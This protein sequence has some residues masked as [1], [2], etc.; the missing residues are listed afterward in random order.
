MHLS[1]SLTGNLEPSSDQSV[2]RTMVFPLISDVILLE[3]AKN[4]NFEFLTERSNEVIRSRGRSR[5][6]T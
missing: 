1:L 6:V 2:G 3:R 5:G 4:E